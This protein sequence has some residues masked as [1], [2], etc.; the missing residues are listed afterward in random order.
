MI[1]HSDYRD[2]LRDLQVHRP[3]IIGIDGQLGAGKTT[4]AKRIAADLRC[5]CIHLDAFLTPGQASFLPSL[6]YP[7]LA[8]ALAGVTGTVI[9][10]GICLLAVLDRLSRVPDYLIFMDTDL[11]RPSPLLTNEQ[12]SYGRVYAPRS[13][14]HRIIRR[15]RS[16]MTNSF[17]VEIA[18]IRSKT[19][20]SILLACG[21]L[22]QTLSGA[23]LLHSGLSPG[24]GALHIMGASISAAPVGGLALCTAISWAY[25]AYLARPGARVKTQS[26]SALGPEGSTDGSRTEIYELGTVTQV[27]ADP[28]LYGGQR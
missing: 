14:A 28:V 13:K 25:I 9:I 18:H 22:A 21:A 23:L 19:A 27:V 6:Q 5:P 3:R 1:E 16:P 15:E 20:I 12:R 24:A 26:R 10:E 2:L 7:R 11:P 4:L 8:A 17:D